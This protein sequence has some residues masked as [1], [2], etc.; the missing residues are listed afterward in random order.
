MKRIAIISDTHGNG[1]Y[2]KRAAT[3]MKD[4]SLLIHLGDGVEQVF[5]HRVGSISHTRGGEE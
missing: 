5:R 4:C 3:K 2:L 1:S